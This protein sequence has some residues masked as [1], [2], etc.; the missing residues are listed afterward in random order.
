[1]QS[2]I[3]WAGSK[4]LLLPV[5]TS[6]YPRASSRYVEPFA[7]SAALFFALQPGD[8]LLTDL[9]SHLINALRAIKASPSLVLEALRRLPTGSRA[10]YRVRAS[11]DEDSSDVERA[12]RFLYLNRYCFNGLYRTNAAGHFNTPYGPPKRPLRDFPTRVHEASL[13]LAG[14]T[15]K[16]QDFEITLAEVREGDFVY[17]DPPYAV[18]NRRIFREYL[19]GSFSRLDLRRLAAGLKAIDKRGATFLLSYARSKEARDLMK[20][21]HSRAV[22]VRRHVAG[23]AA[24]RRS[25]WEVLV[26][27]RPLPAS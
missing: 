20:G 19:Q 21:W 6:A 7:G 1:M 24:H 22:R 26:S 10:Y 23:F 25:A 14:A 8:A 18:D 17:L 12:A 5:L 15:L 27:N 9:N 4:R 13:A 11:R 3:R 2:C 16:A